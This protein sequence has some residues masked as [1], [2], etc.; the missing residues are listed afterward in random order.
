MKSAVSFF[1]ALLFFTSLSSQCP[2]KDSLW[3]I[4]TSLKDQKIV[5]E[6]KQLDSLLG[7][8]KTMS[9]CGYRNDSTHILLLQR[10]GWLYTKKKDYFRAIQYTGNAISLIDKQPHR[11]DIDPKLAIRCY[12]NLNLMY[13]TL[14]ML[15]KKNEAIDSC[16]SRS[17]NL[18]AVY[19]LG[20]AALETKAERLFEIGDYHQCASIAELGEIFLKESDIDAFFKEYYNNEFFYWKINSLNFLKQQSKAEKFVVDKLHQY[21]NTKKDVVLGPLNSLYATVVKQSRPLDAITHY[22]RSYTHSLKIGFDEG[23]AEALNN[24]GFTYAS[25]LHQDQTA[26]PYYFKALKFAS[27]KEALNILGN[28]ANS[29]LQV[30]NY[31]SAF[32]YFQKAFDQIETG[33]NE[34][35]L[36]KEGNTEYSG[37]I[38]EYVA[39]LALDKADAYLRRYKSSSQQKYLQEAIR[40][41]QVMDKYFDKLKIAQSEIQSKL[42]WKAN[43]RRLY[44]HAIEA[45]YVGKNISTAFYFFEKSRSILLNDQITAQRRMDDVSMAKQA[46]LKR[47]ILELERALQQTANTTKEYSAIQRQLYTAKLELEILNKKTNGQNYAYTKNDPNTATLTIPQVRAGILKDRNSLLEIFTGDSSVYVLSVCPNG[48]FFTRVDKNLYDSLTSRYISF[49]VNKAQLNKN[50]AAFVNTSNQLYKLIFQNIQLPPGGS[51]IV[52]PDGKSFPFECL[53]SSMNA[54][55]PHYLLDD[56]ATSYTYSAQY[57]ANQIEASTTNGKSILGIAPVNY[58][59]SFGLAGLPGSDLSLDNI[60]KQ[61][62]TADN[63]ILKNATRK[64]FLQNFS[65]YSIIQLYTHAADN[66]GNNDPVIYFSD[67][68]LSLSDLIADRKPLTQL[69]V[70]SACETANGKLYEG[71]GIFSFNRGFAALGIPAA[72]SNLWSVDNIST[73]RITELFYKYLAEGLE[74]DI[75]LQKAKLEFIKTSNSREE[76]LPYFW[77]G[78]ILVGKVDTIRIGHQFP[79]Q[80]EILLGVILLAA[81]I[82]IRKIIVQRNRKKKVI[83][84]DTKEIKEG[85]S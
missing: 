64:N 83:F 30:G 76:Q 67:S 85:V 44:E 35:Q 80:E 57:L 54:Q 37:K 26:L 84:F 34:T 75:A 79:W 25:I 77:A 60:K 8:E 50:F 32:Y 62:S 13:D 46:Q 47:N 15:Q 20:I 5:A 58:N 53:V 65:D 52:S 10:I 3:R 68:T 2:D 29:Y 66:I 55:S 69:V 40:I 22:K 4:I 21:N 28:V 11:L 82:G 9:K 42:F 33:F 74:T 14:K 45:C 63:Y 59:H 39:G 48:E 24:I 7:Y 41:Y 12:Y 81:G 51:L 27:A 31:D 56:H 23:C 61:F 78:T 49:I 1:A 72:V 16:I 18:H 17:L 19:N 70:L 71:E 38:V 36:L 6:S 73:Y 43:N